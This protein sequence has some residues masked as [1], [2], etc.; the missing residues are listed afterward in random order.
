MPSPLILGSIKQCCDMSVCLSVC[1]MPLVQ[2]QRCISGQWLLENTN[3]KPHAKSLAHWL[4]LPHGH[5]TATKPLQKHSV[6]PHRTAIDSGISFRRAIRCYFPVAKARWELSRHIRFATT[7]TTTTTIIILRV[8][9]LSLFVYSR[10]DLCIS[11]LCRRVGHVMRRG[12]GGMELLGM[13]TL[14]LL[15][16]L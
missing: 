12:S 8:G 10:L 5:E 16:L 11:I 15:L 7:T 6:W 13:L 9:V 3:R 14:L 2:Q 4:A 1:P